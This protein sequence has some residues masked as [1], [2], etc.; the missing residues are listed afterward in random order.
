M[1]NTR[2]IEP[3][4]LDETLRTTVLEVIQEANAPVNAALTTIQT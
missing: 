1:V 2:N 3:R 4:V